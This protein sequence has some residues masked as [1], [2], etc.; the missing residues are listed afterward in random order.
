MHRKRQNILGS[1]HLGGSGRLVKCQTPDFGSGHDLSVCEFKPHIWLCSDSV[2]P[3]WDSLA[4]LLSLLLPCSRERVL[5]L[6]FSLSLSQN[7]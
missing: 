6:L 5:H 4:L 3:A 2:E 1:G 7:R